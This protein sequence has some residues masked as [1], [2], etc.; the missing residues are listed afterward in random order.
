MSDKIIDIGR[1]EPS[2]PK[3]PL[4]SEA[5]RQA[6][7]VLANAM[8]PGAM[9]H[10]RLHLTHVVVRP[11]EPPGVFHILVNVPLGHGTVNHFARAEEIVGMDDD[12]G[13]IQKSE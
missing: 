9:V 11:N 4:E 13:S 6:L 2:N 7:L 10:F 3:E 1:P 12:S 8:P 5:V